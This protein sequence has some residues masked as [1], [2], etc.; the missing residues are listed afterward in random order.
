MSFSNTLLIVDN[1][2]LSLT[3]LYLADDA[4]LGSKVTYKLFSTVL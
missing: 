4:N 1:A 2:L 3:P